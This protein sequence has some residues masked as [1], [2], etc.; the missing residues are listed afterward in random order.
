MTHA[1]QILKNFFTAEQVEYL[2]ELVVEEMKNPR[3]EVTVSFGKYIS[4]S[5]DANNFLRQHLPLLDNETIYIKLLDSLKPIGVH[6]DT[7]GITDLAEFN[8]VGRTLIIPIFECDTHTIIFDHIL[9]DGE[10]IADYAVSLPDID[11]LESYEK[12]Y[13]FVPFE[14][15]KKLKVETIFKWNTGDLLIFDRRRIHCSDQFSSKGINNKRGI[16]IWTE[17]Y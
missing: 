12:Y 10:G 2:R 8:V 4:I 1:T 3:E 17:I 7:T 13:P 15:A 16:V 11:D 6:A 14:W 9:P 5:N